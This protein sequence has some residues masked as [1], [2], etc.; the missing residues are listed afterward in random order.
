MTTGNEC[1]VN[2]A[3]YRAVRERFGCEGCAG[4]QDT[5]LCQELM[6]FKDC[7]REQIVWLR[8]D[9]I[10]SRQEFE[11][12]AY[13]HYLKRKEAGELD[14]SAEGDGSRES[15]FWKTPDGSYGVL[16]FNAAWQGFRWGRGL[17]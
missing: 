1:V 3:R 16:M 4:E 7:Y 14:P 17:E 11:D 6:E 10:D 5:D 9:P 15:M 8:A 13:A 12:A 2:G